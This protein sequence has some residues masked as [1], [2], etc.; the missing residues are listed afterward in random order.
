MDSKQ[1]NTDCAVNH[2]E[3]E[4]PGVSGTTYKYLHANLVQGDLKLMQFRL[5]LTLC[6]LLNIFLC[7]FGFG[8]FKEKPSRACLTQ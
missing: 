4:L 5:V 1:Y 3:N 8:A 2:I 7:S 6:H